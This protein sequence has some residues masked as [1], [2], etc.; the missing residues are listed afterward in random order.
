M[1]IIGTTSKT[2]T[3]RLIYGTAQKVDF[4]HLRYDG[5]DISRPANDH[6]ILL[7][8]IK[9]FLTDLRIWVNLHL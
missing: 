3:A 1:H 2:N 5:H 8:D 9:I 6:S 7:E 4:T